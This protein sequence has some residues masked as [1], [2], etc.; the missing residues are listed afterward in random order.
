MVSKNSQ[1]CPRE[2]RRFC[3]SPVTINTGEGRFCGIGGGKNATCFVGDTYGKRMDGDSMRTAYVILI[4]IGVAAGGAAFYAKH[5]AADP[6]TSFQTVAI[7]RG[8]LLSTIGATGTAEPEE[9][10]DVGARSWV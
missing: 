1:V 5:M 10:V 8:D 6:V 2:Q 4:L 9:V 7:K 3:R